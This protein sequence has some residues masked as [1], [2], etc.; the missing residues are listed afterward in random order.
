MSLFSMTKIVKQ[1]ALGAVL[2][3]LFACSSEPVNP[4]AELVDFEN[5]T[6]IKRLWKVPVGAGDLGAGLALTPLLLDGKIYTIDSEGLLVTVDASTGERLEKRDYEERVLGG[7]AADR[8]CLYYTS[9]QGDLVCIGRE[10]GNQR[11]RRT[12][13]TEVLSPVVSDDRIV[14]VHASDDTV[15]A[16]DASEGN[17]RWR[18]DNVGPVLTLRGTASPVLVNGQA[19]TS[20]SDGELVALDAR[21]GETVWKSN[22]AVAEGRTE[23]ER[24]VDSDG[25]PFVFD[26]RVFA[27]AY[28]GDAVAI[29]LRSGAEVWRQEASS[30]NGLA[31][32]DER[33]VIS[34][35]NGTLL[36]LN[37]QTGK[38]IWRNDIYSY[39]RLKTPVL[40]G[41]LIFVE[42][43]EG[44][45][46]VLLASDGRQ[47]FRL[48]PDS[49]GVMGSPIVDHNR[50]YYYT[51]DG[52]LVAYQIYR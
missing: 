22:L 31:V 1:I 15:L 28:H 37:P 9:F 33:L 21:S 32:S 49:E 50:I 45:V 14:V 42:D 39:R 18:Q 41:N 38:E 5:Q 7:L 27:V 51:R 11:W 24:L 48:R 46:H 26:N 19:I 30:F 29:D 34:L 4:P 35:E 8:L 36:A 43:F 52:Y 23:L 47:A 2:T 25:Q 6:Y 17:Q 44:F 20:F 3:A 16:F 12:I 13:G 10:S 40:T